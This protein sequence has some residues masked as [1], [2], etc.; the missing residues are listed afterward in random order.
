MKINALVL[1]LMMLLLLSSCK[2]DGEGNEDALPIYSI[3][4]NSPTAAEL[5]NGESFQIHIDF[6]EANELTVHHINV[7]ISNA[8]GDVIYDEPSIAHV[9]EDGGHYVHLDDFILDV[10]EGE[11]LTLT[12][13][14]WGHLEGLAEITETISFTA[15]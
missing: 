2:K 15:Q 8:D 1:S 11:V 13:K 9:H 7:Q 3:T 4:I 10:E 5:P 12:A 6:D 14:V